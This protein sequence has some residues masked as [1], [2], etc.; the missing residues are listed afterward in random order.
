M[1]IGVSIT[2]LRGRVKSFLNRGSM[3]PQQP[4][5]YVP[6]RKHSAGNRQ[7]K[8][9]RMDNPNTTQVRRILDHLLD[10]GSIT[11][12][13]AQAMYKCRSITRRIADIRQMGYEVKSDWK[14][15]H[16]GQRYVRYWLMNK[17]P[18]KQAVVNKYIVEEVA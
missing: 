16:T 12:V 1:R 4:V 3:S 10:T 17:T 9:K 11:N 13:E 2:A 8:A 6:P 18:K 5:A 7:R 14:T 15:D